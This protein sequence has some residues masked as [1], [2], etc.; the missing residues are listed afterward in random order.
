M[1][2]T[3][4]DAQAN[5]KSNIVFKQGV[6]SQDINNTTSYEG[7]AFSAGV[8]IGDIGALYFDGNGVRQ[9]KATA[10]EWF[11]K[12]GDNDSQIDCNKYRELNQK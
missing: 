2:T 11:G 5:G 8:S 1:F 9:N 12:A 10:K 4:A 6:T 3:S 7:D